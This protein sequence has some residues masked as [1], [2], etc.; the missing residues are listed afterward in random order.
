MILLSPS[1]ELNPKPKLMVFESPGKE[2][3]SIRPLLGARTILMSQGLIAGS[4]ENQIRSAFKTA[5]CQFSSKKCI[6]RT[7]RLALGLMVL[8]KTPRRWLDF[9]ALLGLPSA[10]PM[11]LSLRAPLRASRKIPSKN[12]NAQ[13][14]HLSANSGLISPGSMVLFLMAYPFLRWTLAPFKCNPAVSVL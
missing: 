5:F 13:S 14:D 11:S 7:A 6:Y 4:D 12:P 3:F 9:G 2:I 8:K 1:S 10:D